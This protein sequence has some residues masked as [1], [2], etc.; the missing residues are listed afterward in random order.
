MNKKQMNRIECAYSF[1]QDFDEVHKRNRRNPSLK[2][3]GNEIV[4]DDS[5]SIILPEYADPLLEYTAVD[6]QDYFRV[7]MNLNLVLRHISSGPSIVLSTEKRKEGKARSFQFEV[8]AGLVRISGTDPAGVAQG[9]Y[10]LEDLMNLREAPFLEQGSVYREPLFSPRMVHSGWGLDQFPDSHLNA[11][12]HAGFDSI[13]LFVK[14]PG[15]TTHGYMDFNNL[16]DRCEKYGLGVYFY[17]YLPSY[18]HPDEPDAEA[19]FDQSYGAVFQASPKAKGLILVG[20]SCR[21]PSRDE[22]TS[23]RNGNECAEKIDYRPLPG[24]FPCRDYPDWLNA[25]KKAVYKYAPHADIV[26][27][28]YNWGR[29]EAAPRIDLINHLPKDVS[30]QATFEMFETI[31]RYPNHQT[32][33]ADYSITFPG[34]GKY[35]KSEAEAAAKRGLR[36]YTMSNTAGRTWDFGVVPYVP[37]PQQWIRRFRAM[38]E[39]HER[40]GLSGVMDSHHFGWFPSEISELAKWCFWSPAVDP[41]KILM[42]IATRDFGADAAE[43]AVRA[44]Q[45]W[46]QAIDSYTPGFDDQAGPLRVGP[47]Y[48]LR[49]KPCLYPHAGYGKIYP[50]SPQSPVGTRWLNPDYFPEHLFNMSSCGRRIPED[51]QIMTKALALWEEGN[52]IMQQALEKVPY[53]K[54]EHAAK[55]VGVG[56]FCSRAIRTMI[57][58]KRW[59]LL[60]R[61]LE[62]EYDFTEAGKILDELDQIIEAEYDNVERTIPLVEADSRLGWEPS[63]DY[64]GGIRQLRW[65]LNYLETLRRHTL[66]DYRKTLCKNPIMLYDQSEPPAKSED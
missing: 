29:V 42:K 36:L 22:R 13:L 59:W 31:T 16:I 64:I 54:L 6:L 58:T 51:I 19:F 21:F 14:G 18:K 46:S 15:Q 57:H 7:S 45:L 10:Y 28:T 25:V 35:F 65:K 62:I 43:L 56:E 37:V 8:T 41:D 26:F 61:R 50:T 55:I 63:M 53:A 52:T 3:M 48:P 20:E 9:G 34:P 4:I 11:I 32:V 47:S 30:L 5:W 39:A 38:Q 66:P 1:R 24:Y 49:F 17:S 2:P 44:W 23:G 27:W 40:W 12:A 60:N 33:Q